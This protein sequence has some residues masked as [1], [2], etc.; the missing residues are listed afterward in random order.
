MRFTAS[1]KTKGFRFVMFTSPLA[2]AHSGDL[3]NTADSGFVF[4]EVLV[5]LLVEMQHVE[6]CCQHSPE[7][8]FIR[9]IGC[10]ARL[11]FGA[12]LR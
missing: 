8:L 3:F 10:E 4:G 9:L 11:E 1:T 5:V 2:Q 12:C 7:V 6:K